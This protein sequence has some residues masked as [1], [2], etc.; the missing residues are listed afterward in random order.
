MADRTAFLNIVRS[1][2][3]LAELPSTPPELP[4]VSPPALSDVAVVDHFVA[5][6][7]KVDGHAHLVEPDEVVGVVRQLLVEYG[8][9]DVMAWSRDEL[10]VTGVVEAIGDVGGRLIDTVTPH[11]THRDHNRGY[12]HANIGITGADAA[13]A[14]SGSI[15]VTSGAG[16]PR[17][18]SLIPLVHIALLT[19]SKI[20]RSLTHFMTSDPGAIE[21][22]ANLVCITGP[23]RT[24]DIEQELNL[25]VHGP[26]H[27]HVIVITSL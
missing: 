1:A 12:T 14:E 5:Q 10:P 20:H 18:A 3:R 19:A 13:F 17:M 2:G 25:G 22:G 26:K 27:L 9:G 4:A 24:G 16:R 21:R 11:T 8:G 6:L 23:S 15:V 7:E